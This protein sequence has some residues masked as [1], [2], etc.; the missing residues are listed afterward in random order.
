MERV[1]TDN[2][3]Y[4]CRSPT[5]SLDSLDTDNK[6]YGATDV[7]IFGTWYIPLNTSERSDGQRASDG[8]I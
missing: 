4:Y 3:D 7:P 2:Y 5:P 1:D 8:V 6:E